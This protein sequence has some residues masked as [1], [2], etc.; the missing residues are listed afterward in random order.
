MIKIMNLDTTVTYFCKTCQD[1][2]VQL[3]SF[4]SFLDCVL[5]KELKKPL[6]IEKQNHE[7]NARQSS[8]TIRPA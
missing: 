1:D 7:Y 8:P 5:Y 2:H 4:P 6:H 3:A